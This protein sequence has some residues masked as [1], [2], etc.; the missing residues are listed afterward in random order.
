LYDLWHN[1]QDQCLFSLMKTRAPDP[2]IQPSLGFNLENWQ[3]WMTQDKFKKFCLW[4]DNCPVDS[5]DDHS[6]RDQYDNNQNTNLDL[7]N[8][9]DQFEIEL[10]AETYTRGNTFFPTEKTVRPIMAAKPFIVYGPRNFLSRLRDLGFQT[11]GNCWD[12]SYDQ[13][14]GPER[15]T[16][17]QQLLGTNLTADQ[18]IA[19]HN[20]KHLQ[21]MI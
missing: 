12:E 18:K 6:V 3:E 21:S 20:R 4:F 9:Y 16:K 5:L 17:I 8:F 1:H 15:W 13:Y 7:L 14:E 2:W 19:E 10:V 11:Y